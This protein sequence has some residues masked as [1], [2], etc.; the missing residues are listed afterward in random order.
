MLELFHYLGFPEVASEH[1]QRLDQM[2]SYVH[3]L[4]LIL[5]V[6]WGTYFIYVLFRFRA[7]KNPVPDRLGVKSKASSYA[8]AGV[9]LAEVALIVGFAMPLWAERVNEFPETKDT[10]IVRVVAEQF[11]WNVHYPGPDGIFGRTNIEDIDLQNNPLGL[12]KTDPN[13]M[14]DI[15]TVNQLF[16]PV[17][18]P[19]LIYLSSKDVIHSFGIPEMRVK[20][21]AIP[22]MEIPLWFVPTITSNDMKEIVDEKYADLRASRNI[23]GKDK[24]IKKFQTYEIACAQL[25]GMGHYSMRGFVN[26]LTQ[27]EFDE[28]LAKEL[29]TLSDDYDIW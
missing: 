18:R 20:Q 27:E 17:D 16:L 6:G 22:G 3:W 24:G 29:P 21:D 8:E 12:D 28:W 1:G 7:S 26:V 9:V 5:F 11:A 15:T 23:R 2:L 25:C 4:M 19:V 13:A 14:D 10:V